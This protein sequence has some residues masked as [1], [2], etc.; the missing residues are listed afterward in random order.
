MHRLGIFQQGLCCNGLHMFSYCT[1]KWNL[2]TGHFLPLLLLGSSSLKTQSHISLLRGHS[3]SPLPSPVSAQ[4]SAVQGAWGATLSSWGRGEAE[5]EE[6]QE[7]ETQQ[8]LTA[9]KAQEF[10]RRAQSTEQCQTGVTWE[11]PAAPAS[12]GH[13]SV[14]HSQDHW[15]KGGEK[16]FLSSFM[17]IKTESISKR[18]RWGWNGQMFRICPQPSAL[19]RCSPDPGLWTWFTQSNQ[20]CFFGL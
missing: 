15:R 20:S 17:G 10:P 12:L 5:M 8:S 19:V 13:T 7:G 18:E 3:H 9:S 4:P 2:A 16:K 1:P 6:T 11:P 14:Q